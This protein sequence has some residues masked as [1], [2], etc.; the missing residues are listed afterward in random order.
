VKYLCLTYQDERKVDTLSGSELDAIAAACRLYDEA[1]RRS[2]HLVATGALQPTRA[3]TT[4]RP[5]SGRVAIADGPFAETREQVGAFFIIEARD[6][7]EAIRVASQH[8]AAHLGERLGWG[9]EVRPI[10]AFEQP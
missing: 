4:V 6:L 2:G 10:D 3:T 7:N 1:L 9:V 8:P 5:R